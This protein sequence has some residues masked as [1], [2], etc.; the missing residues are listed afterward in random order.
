MCPA[1]RDDGHA[2]CQSCGKV[3]EAIRPEDPAYYFGSPVP[4]EIRPPPVVPKVRRRRL[5]G[6]HDGRS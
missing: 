5:F 4:S 1:A 6:W 3:F 2:E